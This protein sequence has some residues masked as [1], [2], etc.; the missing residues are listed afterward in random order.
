MRR[1]LGIAALAAGALYV[2]AQGSGAGILN[3]Y[4]KK[5]NEAQS[6]TVDYS[7]QQVG[8]IKADYSVTM[9]KPNMVRI[10]KPNEL[11]VA[12]GKTI[13]TYSKGE[14]TFFKQPQTADGLKELVGSDELALWKSFFDANA[15]AS[16]TSKSLGS[17]T[18]KGQPYQLVEMA[19]DKSGKK[20]VTLYIAADSMAKIGEILLN[21]PNGKVTYIVDTKNVQV[22]NSV[23]DA[24]AFKAPEGARELSMEELHASTWYTNLEEAKKIAAKTNR[25]IFVDFMATWCG[26]CKMLEHDVLSTDG[27]KKMSNKIVFLQI[28][29]DA[30]PSVSQ[31]YGITA[32]PTQ[33]VLNP[34]GTVVSK[35]V[36]YG[37][38]QA[39]YSWLN[40]A[41]K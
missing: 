11:I 9:S 35:T 17:K 29:V 4:S 6:L 10:D 1:I 33:M 41:L 32:M 34:D 27:F 30:Q 3:A 14:K 20:V 18:R 2:F 12:D 37:G 25:K 13:T 8:G 38:P 21:D 16:T 22:N 26:P 7:I 19:A 36:G 39:F 5:L 24:F 40:G 23:T 15:Y 31:A 28:D